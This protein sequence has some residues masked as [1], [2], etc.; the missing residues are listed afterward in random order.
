MAQA[1]PSTTCPHYPPSNPAP[2][3]GAGASYRCRGCGARITQNLH[4]TLI[5]SSYPG[6][7]GRPGTRAAALTSGDCSSMG[8]IPDNGAV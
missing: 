1:N 6:E 3:G 2:A 7:A 4:S 5:H 8:G